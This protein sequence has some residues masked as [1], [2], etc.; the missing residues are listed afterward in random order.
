MAE[1]EGEGSGEVGALDRENDPK[2]RF[3]RDLFSAVKATLLGAD[4]S[5]GE[6]VE[7]T[8]DMLAIEVVRPELVPRR[9]GDK[10]RTVITAKGLPSDSAGKE[11]E[12]SKS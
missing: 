6:D 8:D 3:L 10:G 4:S 12:E 7:R 1:S 5:E 2:E 9:I 11:Q